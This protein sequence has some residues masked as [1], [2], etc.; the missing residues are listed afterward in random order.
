MTR[1]LMA[2]AIVG[3]CLLVL[4]VTSQA[5]ESYRLNGTLC[6]AGDVAEYAISPDGNR[7][8]YRADQ[9]ADGVSELYSVPI[10]GGTPT[11]LNGALVANGDVH[12]F[13]I[14]PDG[15]RV[16]YRADQ[17]TDGVDELYSVPIGGGTATKLN[18]ALVANGDVLDFAVSPDGSRVVYRADQTTDEVIELYSVPIGGG[19]ATKLNG[20]LVA[21]G[22]VWD[23][24]ISPDGSRVVYLADQATEG[25]DELYSVPIGGGTPMKLNGALV[26]N[27]IVWDF[28]VTPDG[29]RVVYCA[30]QTTDGVGE[31]YSVPIG[32]GTPTKLNG[33]LVANGD[34]RDFAI[35]P[36]G[37]R[38]V[39]RADQTTDEVYELFSVPIGGGTPMKLNGALVV[40]G[41]VAGYAI[42][43]D[44]SRVVYLADQ[45]TDGVN[46]LYS[47]PI[48]G[49]TAMKLN[50][51]L[52][53][54]GDVWNWLISPDGSRVVYYADQN[55]D[56]VCELYSVPIG[57]GTPTKLN[58]ALV[59]NGDVWDFA[60][61]P[62]GSRV[63]YRAD[64]TTDE[65]YELFSV[66]IGGG[67]P[68]KLN[69]ALVANG[70]VYS[71]FRISP[72]GSRVVYQADQTT[73]GVDE[74]FVARGPERWIAAGGSWNTAA[75]WEFGI[76]P[77]RT[78]DVVLD[79]TAVTTV[80]GGVVPRIVDTLTLGGGAGASIL[81]LKNGAVVS[82]LHGITVAAGGVLR[83]DGILDGQGAS[84]TLPAG[85]EIRVAEGQNLRV[86]AGSLANVGRI[87]ALGNAAVPA[88]LDLDAAVTNGAG[89]GLITGHDA[90]LRFRVR[91]VNAGA[92]TLAGGMNDVLGA[93][94]N[95]PGGSILVSGGATALFYDDIANSGTIRVSASGSTVSRA[96]FFGALS[97]GGVSGT[98]AVFLEGDARPGFSPGTMSFG[99]DVS[100]GTFATVHAE[101]AGTAP[102]SQYDV[103][104]V[105]GHLELGGALE[106]TLT[107]GFVPAAGM[108][109]DVWDAGTVAGAF[110]G[111]R[112][113]VLPSGRF[114]HTRDLNVTGVL[115]VGGTPERYAAYAAYYALVL[116]PTGD[117]D[118]DGLPNVVEFALGLDARTPNARGPGLLDLECQVVN[119]RYCF[120]MPALSSPDLVLDVEV[121][122]DMKAWTPL[123]RRTAGGPWVGTLPPAL[124]ALGGGMETV[125][126]TRPHGSKS[127]QFYRLR[128]RL[129][130]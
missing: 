73:D 70:D 119:D 118:G 101:L 121:S 19:T 22:D 126:F 85:A 92:F 102:G 54:G 129:A 12:D 105:A 39:Y 72:D 43:P 9:D 29:S 77:D 49:G 100:L 79:G 82:V 52:V 62:D 111:V 17:T 30:D 83:G 38:V 75:N 76:S 51:T 67:T 109:F 47:V 116:P 127:P 93:I 78:T 13:A 57:G 122:G 48:G 26:A 44:G 23:F 61:S 117:D 20:A 112:L 5:S 125:T 37:S 8:V 95:Q 28:A 65:V 53:A 108:S 41:D 11:K 74:L 130:Q 33:A 120:A 98:G 123:A 107:G 55:A 89:T 99:G 59:A 124:S 40:N 97:G 66:P 45:A 81:D 6:P 64:Q 14:S 4:G 104:D 110:A 106:V 24:A 114:W 90:V 1:D 56:A 128:V 50:G 21:N 103:F 84:L 31:L 87:E 18:G 91:L 10:G 71:G 86:V 35:S 88:E 69:G 2:V 3:V 27:G 115:S 80:D 36:D 58:G 25:V 34:V 32:G 96:V 16:V 42:S 94:L 60:V 68:M 7:V 63:V 113:P 46:E 15:S